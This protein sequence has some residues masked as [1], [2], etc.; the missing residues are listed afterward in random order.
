M[1]YNFQEN[2]CSII[3]ISYKMYLTIGFLFQIFIVPAANHIIFEA[4]I[5]Y[6]RLFE[7]VR[8]VSCREFGSEFKLPM[9]LLKSVFHAFQ[10]ERKNKCFI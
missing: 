8:F 4:V 7:S 6:F 5:F 3:Y 10:H 1:L 9:F 2:K